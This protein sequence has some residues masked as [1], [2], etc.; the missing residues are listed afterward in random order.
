MKRIGKTI[1]TLMLSAIMLLGVTATASA[2]DSS[3]TFHGSEK[4]FTF[5]PGS[6]YT[7]TDL[8]DNFKNVMPGDVVKEEITF[9][10]ADKKHGFI[11]LY[12][13]AETHDE[14]G[15]PLSSSVAAEENAVTMADFLSQLSMKVWNGTELIYQA[16]PD[17][18]DGL[19]NNRFLGTF[20]SGET[21]TLTVELS[22]PLELGNE[23]AYRVGEVDWIFHVEAFEEGKITVQK[24]WSDGAEQHKDGSVTVQLFKN[25]EVEKTVELNASNQWQYTFDRLV[26]G[27]SW[28]V[29]EADV[30]SGYTVSYKLEG[31]NVV[32]TNTRIPDAPDP[33]EPTPTPT[34][35]PNPAP[36]TPVTP[37]PDQGVLG[38][39]IP[40][41]VLV[42]SVPDQGVL[43]AVRT[44]DMEQ[45]LLWAGLM[46]LALIVLAVI[47][48]RK[49]DKN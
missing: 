39:S 48:F 21:T 45:P 17:E 47:A 27:Y 20:R 40:P 31:T 36:D 43:G 9:T 2:A 34:P 6:E 8:F 1:F 19:K 12:L 44:G 41:T 7:E 4:G 3:V 28:K 30:P 32:I 26:E 29:A 25:D 46:M 13:R 11:N 37:V 22:V 15:N 16:S 35:T 49:R 18:L 10:N 5:K 38:V 24:V 33:D 23:Y 42:P 14:N